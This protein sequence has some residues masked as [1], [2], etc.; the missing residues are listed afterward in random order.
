VI[1]ASCDQRH[2]SPGPGEPHAAIAAETVRPDAGPT[3]VA[4]PRIVSLSPAITASVVALGIGDHVV[5]R[6]P[7]CDSVGSSVPIVG[8]LNDFDAERLVRLNPTHLLVQPPRTGL[9]PALAQLAKGRGWVL[10]AEPLDDVE[11]IR[12]V[13]RA[14]PAVL[15]GGDPVLRARLEGKA[16]DLDA[17]ILAA[18]EGAGGD[19]PATASPVLLLFSVDPPRAFG[20]GSYLGD[21]LERLGGRNALDV[22]GYPE[23]SMEDVV[24]LDP[25]T[26]VLVRTVDPSEGDDPLS[27]LRALDV[28]A[29][30]DDRLRVLVHPAALTP[31]PAVAELSRA[32]ARTL[33]L[34]A[35]AVAPTR[36]AGASGR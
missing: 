6:T 24:R 5:G 4:P 32:L 36:S 22:Q 23:L 10:F 26:I 3:D 13:L 12:G 11:D 8:D 33:A 27:A 9:D 2:E 20:P 31:G 19:G 7:W 29:V 15:G 17:T 1:L 14:L 30:R 16:A 21:L 34:T 35:G 28:A 25:R 18:L